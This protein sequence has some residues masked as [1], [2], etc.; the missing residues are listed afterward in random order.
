MAD[1]RIARDGNRI[2]IP[3]FRQAGELRIACAMLHQAVHDR[4]YSDL[5]LDF[6]NCEVATEAAMLPLLPIVTSMRE[7]ERIDFS[8]IEPDDETSRL[9]QDMVIPNYHC[10]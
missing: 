6:S 10:N 7:V 2:S 4:G 8:L 9:I 5:V 3:L 1:D